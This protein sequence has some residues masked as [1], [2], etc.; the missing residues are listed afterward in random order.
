MQKLSM[1]NN[2]AYNYSFKNKVL[3]DSK[4]VKESNKGFRLFVFNFF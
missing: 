3:N 4:I 1:E 2:F